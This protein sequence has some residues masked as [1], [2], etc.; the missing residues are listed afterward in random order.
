MNRLSNILNIFYREINLLKKDRN[1]ISVLIIAP[2]FYAFFYGS[3]YFNKSEIDVP[4]TVVDND[5]SF[6][7]NRLI[8]NLDSHQLISIY[9]VTKDFYEA[10][11]DFQNLSSQAIIVIP[12]DFENKIKKGNGVQLKLYLN[13]TRF[14]ISNDVN[15]SVNEVIL[16]TNSL[17][18]LKY[19]QSQG[20]SYDQAKE[21]IEPVRSEIKSLYNFTD[22]YGDF[23]IPAILILILHQTLLIGLAESFAKENENST[24]N[25]LYELSNKSIH[26]IILGKGLIYL[27][28]YFSYTLFFFNVLFNVF[29]IPFVGSFILFSFLTLLMI[30]STVTLAI[31]ISTFFNRKILAIQYLALSSYPIFLISGY[32]WPEESLPF[33]LKIFSWLI[34]FTPFS[35]VTI[36]ITQMGASINNVSATLVHLFFL[37]IIYY[38][39]SYIRLNK[40][41]KKTNRG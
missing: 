34:P 4:I 33:F 5:N 18:R 9:K 20:Y 40:L 37:A 13:S 8:R 31:F 21:M 36:K 23:L 41:I 38:T 7:S 39:I 14:L 1:L 25:E 17:I 27:I 29:K 19:F 3:I 24:L 12:S 11:N 32:S 35:N 2:V 22:S 28:L 30:F 6:L 10:K 26:I 15:K 16:T